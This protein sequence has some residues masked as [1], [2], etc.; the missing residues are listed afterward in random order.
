[1][2]LYKENWDNITNNS[3]ILDISNGLMDYIN[4]LMDYINFAST[5]NQ[6]GVLEILNFSEESE[7][8]D[9][10]IN[11]WLTTEAIKEAE[12]CHG[13]YISNIFKRDKKNGDIRIILNLKEVDKHK[14]YMHFKINS[15][16]KIV[17]LVT[18]LLYD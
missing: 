9:Q 7:A 16:G 10:E 13:E 18:T 12:H 5:Q 1:M 8:M 14:K 6:F 3:E 2:K 4:G 17:E 11:N 15:F